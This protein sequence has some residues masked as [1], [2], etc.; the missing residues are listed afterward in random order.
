MIRAIATHECL[1]LLRSA[2]TWVIAALLALLFGYLFLQQLES[3]I[4]VQDQLALQ[5]YPVGLSGF[6]SVRRSCSPSLHR[7]LPCVYSVMSSGSTP[8]LYG[9][10]PRYPAQR[11]YW[12]S[13]QV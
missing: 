9:N 13:L 6:M 3:F 2:Q 4:A 8:T 10:P 1:G 5:D 12:E 11:L 7:C